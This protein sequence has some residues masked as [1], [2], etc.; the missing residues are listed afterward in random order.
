MDTWKNGWFI[1]KKDLR[2]DR[3]HLIGNIIFMIYI[4]ISISTMIEFR[5][6]TERVLQPFSDFMMLL[7][8]PLTGFF[9]SRRSFNYIKE[10]C[11]TGMLHYY[12]ALPIAIG[13]IMKARIIQLVTALIFNGI[14]FYPLLYIMSN[15]LRDNLNIGQYIVFILTWNGFALLMNGAYIYFELLK[16]GRTY[17]WMT[18]SVVLSVAVITVVL[19]VVNTNLVMLTVDYSNRFSFLSPLM[20]GALIIGCAGFTLMAKLTQR[21]LAIRDLK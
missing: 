12:R 17:F 14:I 10:D 8:I 7:V 3:L 20:W 18:T 11:Y 4:G 21:K 2:M 15:E 6:E 19:R 13:T 5:N 9:F 1:F 16:K